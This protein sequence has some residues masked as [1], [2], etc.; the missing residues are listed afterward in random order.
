[1]AFA[2]ISDEFHRRN[3]KS[4]LI[5][6][7]RVSGKTSRGHA[8]GVRVMRAHSEKDS[9]AAVVFDGCYERDVL[10]LHA[11]AIGIVEDE[12]V[13]WA[14]LVER[15]PLPGSRSLAKPIVAI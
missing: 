12:H 10:K 15:E 8:A 3:D 14:N 7:R 2:A 1:M 11:A 6:L 13:P 5:L 9:N 4:L